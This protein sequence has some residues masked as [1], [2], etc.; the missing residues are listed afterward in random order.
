MKHCLNPQFKASALFQRVSRARH[1]PFSGSLPSSSGYP[2][3]PARVDLHYYRLSDPGPSS[4]VS[5]TVL[6]PAGNRRSAKS[7]YASQPHRSGD[8]QT[9]HPLTPWAFLHKNQAAMGKKVDLIP[10][11]AHRSG[12]YSMPSRRDRAPRGRRPRYPRPYR[13]G[14]RSGSPRGR[15]MPSCRGGRSPRNSR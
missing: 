7:S 15:N 3:L 4:I 13:S 1:Q 6:R 5:G 8:R 9:W 11:S 14:G 2:S 10:L 12:P